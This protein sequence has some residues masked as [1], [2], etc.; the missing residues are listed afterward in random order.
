VSSTGTPIPIHADSPF[1]SFQMYIV[2]TLTSR[3]SL[4]YTIQYYICKH[5]YITDS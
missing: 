1:T 5:E 2:Q 4:C 3:F